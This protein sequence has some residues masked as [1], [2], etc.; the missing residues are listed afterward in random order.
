MRRRGTARP[1]PPSTICWRSSRRRA[2][3]TAA[4]PP[5][6]STGC[7]NCAPSRASRD[8]AAPCARRWPRSRAART[9]SCWP[10]ATPIGRAACCAAPATGS[11]SSTCRRCRQPRPPRRCAGSARSATGTTT[12]RSPGCST[13]WPPAGRRTCPTLAAA[14]AAADGAGR[15]PVHA[16]ADQMAVGAP[17]SLAC[18]LSYEVRLG[19]ARGYG[20]LKAILH[21]L[22]DEERLTLT[23]IARRLSRTPGSTRDYLLWL[24]DVDLVQ[25]G[26]EA[27]RLRRSAAAAVGPPPQSTHAARP[28]RSAPRGVRSTPSPGCPSWRTRSSPIRPSAHARPAAPERRWSIIEID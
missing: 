17:L 27:L 22:A 24:E 28:G 10:R 1:G 18:R 25:G 4:P 14:L 21:L 15:D 20:A 19:R 13:R 7:W 26:T 12:P 16:L 3:R 2:T 9:G 6:S 8:C 11:S 23:E 5:F